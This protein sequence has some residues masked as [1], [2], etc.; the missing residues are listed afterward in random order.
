MADD[1]L[2]GGDGV[3]T[4]EDAVPG[5]RAAG[6]LEDGVPTGGGVAV[7]TERVVPGGGDAGEWIS[8]MVTDGNRAAE[9]AAEDDEETA[10]EEVGDEQRVEDGVVLS[11]LEQVGKQVVGAGV[12]R[13]MPK[14]MRAMKAFI[15]VWTDDEED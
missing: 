10:D 2:T 1:M 7:A 4:A 9:G 14:L 8:G 3:L 6:A 15:R 5:G 11:W 12:V 13:V